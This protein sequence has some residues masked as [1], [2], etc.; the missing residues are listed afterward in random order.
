MAKITIFGLAGTGTSS[1][2]K[3]LAQDLG[4][5]YLSSGN[6]FRAK[7]TSLGL[8]LHQFEELC[9]SNP[10]HDKALDTEIEQFGKTHANFV[11]ESRLA[12]Y[13]IPDSFK[14][15]LICD[16]DERLKR[17]AGRDHMSLDE[18][19]SKTLFREE[20]GVKRYAETY[21]ITDFAP[22]HIFD[23]VIDT[24]ETPI[25]DVVEAIKAALK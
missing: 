4:Y 11:V 20:S 23:L 14:V 13:F 10:E 6:I 9:I 17:V 25:L 22:D 2:G 21:S 8:D 24:T 5:I 19:K 3:K 7:A 15:K 12:W 1:V 18:A 16:F